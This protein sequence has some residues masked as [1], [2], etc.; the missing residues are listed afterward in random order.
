VLAGSLGVSALCRTWDYVYFGAAVAAVTFAVLSLC[1][2][3][4]EPSAPEDHLETP[5]EGTPR[6]D[7]R[8]MVLP[9]REWRRGVV[10]AAAAVWT[11][12]FVGGL[13]LERTTGAPWGWAA[14]ELL[15]AAMSLSLWTHVVRRSRSR[16][17]TVPG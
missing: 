13:F 9:L 3:D 16:P 6:R 2:V 11:L 17:R 10:T 1:G 15:T 14:R 7:V 5:Q 8:R 4:S 12:L